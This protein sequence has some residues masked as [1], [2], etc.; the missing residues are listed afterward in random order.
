MLASSQSRLCLGLGG[1]G[2]CRAGHFQ[3]PALGMP[4]TS[5]SQPLGMLSHSRGLVSS[6]LGG[7]WR[8]PQTC[9]F[10]LYR[11]GD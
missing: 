3:T 11:W 6:E 2:E 4:G 10:P 9:S 5:S 7:P 8:I 1:P